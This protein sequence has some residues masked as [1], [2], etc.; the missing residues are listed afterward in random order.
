MN[1]MHAYFK[2]VLIFNEFENYLIKFVMGII[3]LKQDL[4]QLLQTLMEW[5]L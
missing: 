3:H 5:I 2:H 1:Y 4:S